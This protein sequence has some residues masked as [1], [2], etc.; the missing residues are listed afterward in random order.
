[1]TFNSTSLNVNFKSVLR[2]ECFFQ[3]HKGIAIND[4]LFILTRNGDVH[5]ISPILRPWLQ[6]NII[7][8]LPY[9][10]EGTA[11]VSQRTGITGAT[12]LT[13][14]I[15]T[16]GTLGTSTGRNESYVF[17]G[18]LIWKE[19]ELY[20]IGIL[21]GR[22]KRIQI[23]SWSFQSQ[24][25]IKLPDFTKSTRKTILPLNQGSNRNQKAIVINGRPHCIDQFSCSY[26]SEND[27]IYIYGGN[28]EVEQATSYIYEFSFKTK[29]WRRVQSKLLQE[30]KELDIQQQTSWEDSNENFGNNNNLGLSNNNNLWSN[31]FGGNFEQFTEF[32]MSQPMNQSLNY[33]TLEESQ[34]KQIS[35]RRGSVSQTEE[36]SFPVD[37]NEL[38]FTLKNLSRRSSLAA[39]ES[40][41]SFY[42][43]NSRTSEGSESLEDEN[44]EELLSS[45]NPKR[46]GHSSVIWKDFIVFFGGMDEFYY[47]HNDVWYYH[48]PSSTWHTIENQGERIPCPRY[49]HQSVIHNNI[50][51][52]IGGKGNQLEGNFD[53]LFAFSLITQT[54]ITIELNIEFPKLKSPLIFVSDDQLMIHGG[55]IVSPSTLYT[56]SN[57]LSLTSSSSQTVPFQSQFGGT[58]FQTSQSSHNQNNQFNPILNVEDS[59]I[60]RGNRSTTLSH[61]GQPIQ[62][63]QSIHLSGDDFSKVGTQEFPQINFSNPNTEIINNTTNITTGSTNLIHY[64]LISDLLYIFELPKSSQTIFKENMLN[65]ESYT[66][67]VLKFK[68][69][70]KRKRSWE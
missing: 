52:I 7:H 14:L 51:Y 28:T 18:H 57:R 2:S 6:N 67:L 20:Y 63:M 61:P 10:I 24:S 64:Q 58:H 30:Y 34:L 26:Y 56:T 48:I 33:P 25:W 44:I 31:N 47:L 39:D 11:S 1:M 35:S 19:N 69:N 62:S 29:T 68:E 13:N 53:E 59:M 3:N 17:R 23:F 22:N 41:S 21:P 43:K 46:R 9:D 66:D 37:T 40:P 54:W 42:E 12:D 27:C 70:K 16:T 45:P 65:C 50:M 8:P 49:Q 32:T 38:P 4:Q 60:E 15:G 55:K 36:Y 5:F